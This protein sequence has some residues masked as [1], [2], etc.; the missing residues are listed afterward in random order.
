MLS[1]I[2]RE[3][4]LGAGEG[5]DRGWDGWMA[6]PTQWTWVC[7]NSRSWTC[8]G[9]PGVLRFIGSQSQTRLSDW[10][11]LASIRPS[12]NV[13]W[14][15]LMRPPWSTCTCQ[16]WQFGPLELSSWHFFLIAPFPQWS[17][18]PLPSTHRHKIN[19]LLLSNSVDTICQLVNFHIKK[20]R[21]Y[22]ANKG[23]SS[24][25]FPV[26]M[27]GCESWTIKKAEH[28]RIDAFELWWWRRL[29]GVPWTA[30][31]LNSQS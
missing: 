8:T 31:R 7:V 23:P 12:I 19:L 1:S 16:T 22:F 29:L 15:D 25:V 21:H 30:R 18:V 28:R 6:S 26:V 9:R 3:L 2:S 14:A 11:E 17:P 20:H 10:I 24:Q 27:Y 13:K 5:D 4:R